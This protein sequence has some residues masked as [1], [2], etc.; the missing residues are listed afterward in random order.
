MSP[1]DGAVLIIVVSPQGIPLV[2]DE[3]KPKPRY[4]KLPGGKVEPGETHMAAAHRELKEETGLVVEEGEIKMI[5]YISKPT[6]V[7]TVFHAELPTLRE[8]ASRGIE[9]EEV[10]IFS[11]DGVRRLSDLLPAHRK[12]LESNKV[13]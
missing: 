7:L 11:L 2:R 10:E 8:I 13:I 4:W 9:G 1:S 6:H 5:D 3:T 12:I